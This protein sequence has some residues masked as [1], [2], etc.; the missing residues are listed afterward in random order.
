LRGWEDLTGL[1]WVIHPFLP[2]ESAL[3]DHDWSDDPE[4]PV[5]HC[6]DG[7]AMLALYFGA[8]F[9]MPKEKHRA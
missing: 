5:M 7:D 6:Y 8:D 3:Q 9:R 1:K 4:W 2:F